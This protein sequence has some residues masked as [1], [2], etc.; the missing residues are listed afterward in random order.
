MKNQEVKIENGFRAVLRSVLD[1]GGTVLISV[2]A[3]I[4]IRTYVVQPFL[5]S[6]SS[7][8]PTFQDGNY[9]LIDEI[10][11]HLRG[12][13]R[14][15]VIVFKY[16]SNPKTFYVKRVIGLPGEAVEIKN[17][18]VSVKKDGKEVVLE[19]SYVST[20][21]TDGDFVSVLGDDEYFMMGDNRNFSFDSSRWGPLKSNLI[22]GVVRLRLWPINEVMAFGSP[23]Y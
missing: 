9:L 1:I 10:S 22:I 23:N 19:E 16:P 18:Q 20:R 17:N 4:V 2:A 8:E 3:V 21:E 14:G 12:P 11:Y 15:E 5:V 6:G 13:K 7:M